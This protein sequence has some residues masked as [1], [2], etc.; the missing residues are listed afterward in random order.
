MLER[1]GRRLRSNWITIRKIKDTGN[2]K[3]KHW[4]ALCG[5][6]TL[7]EVMDLSQDRKQNECPSLLAEKFR[8][9]SVFLGEVVQNVSVPL[10]HSSF[11]VVLLFEIYKGATQKASFKAYPSTVAVSTTVCHIFTILIT[12]S[13]S[14][15]HFAGNKTRHDPTRT[16]GT[17]LFYRHAFV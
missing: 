13:A 15:I 7:E 10:A 12:S 6:L 9:F 16:R 14:N 2:W 11:V 5:V 17:C 4:I 1:R 8:N 3:R